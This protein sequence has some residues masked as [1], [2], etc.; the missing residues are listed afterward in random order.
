M[1]SG[2]PLTPPNSAY[3]IF[4]AFMFLH[5]LEG[6]LSPE[7]STEERFLHW[8]SLTGYKYETIRYS[9]LPESLV[10]LKCIRRDTRD[11]IVEKPVR[12]KGANQRDRFTDLKKKT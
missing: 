8:I 9:Q 7:K 5:I 1:F 11:G 10:L 6:E 12:I 3:Q 2:V 4:I